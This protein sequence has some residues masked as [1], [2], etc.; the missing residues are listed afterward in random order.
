MSLPVKQMEGGDIQINASLEA[1]PE[2]RPN[3]VSKSVSP[4]ASLNTSVGIGSGSIL[5]GRFWRGPENGGASLSTHI[6]LNTGVN[7]RIYISPR[8]G[9]VSAGIGEFGFGYGLSATYHYT[10]NDKIGLYTGAG[11]FV[12]RHDPNNTGFAERVGYGITS[13]S[14]L[15]Y[16]PYNGLYINVEL[17]PIFQYN[18][19][20]SFNHFIPSGSLS[21]G[22]TFER[23]RD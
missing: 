17:I 5:S 10:L 18:T 22:Y 11:V 7:S 19:F 8:I 2:T 15:S 12:G 16:S 23:N 14:G 9:F 3:E 20:E 4:A 6:A 13:N 1:A 21:V